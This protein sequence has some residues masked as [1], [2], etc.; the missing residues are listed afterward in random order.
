[1]GVVSS[2]EDLSEVPEIQVQAPFGDDEVTSPGRPSTSTAFAT[3]YQEAHTTP[4]LS[5][6]HLEVV[7]SRIM[8]GAIVDLPSLKQRVFT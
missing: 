7:G 5:L 4:A 2:A 3:G 8:L 6:K 1:M